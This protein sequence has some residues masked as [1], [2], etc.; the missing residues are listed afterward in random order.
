MTVTDV[1]PNGSTVPADFD[2]V[3]VIGPT[4]SVAVDVNVPTFQPLDCVASTVM[5]GAVIAGA[6]VSLHRDGERF[7]EWFPC[8]SVA[9]TVTVVV[10]RA[11]VAPEDFE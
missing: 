5:F 2:H 1:V 9:V 4:A 10:P 11:K 7:E 3:S 6:V 8:A